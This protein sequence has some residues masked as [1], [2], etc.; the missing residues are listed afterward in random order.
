M[1][2]VLTCQQRLETGNLAV[3]GVIFPRDIAIKLQSDLNMAKL[4]NAKQCTPWLRLL[5]NDP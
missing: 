2:E 3:L 5:E 4:N 1:Q